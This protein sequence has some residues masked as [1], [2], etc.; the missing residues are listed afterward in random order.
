MSSQCKEWTSKI[1]DGWLSKTGSGL[2]FHGLTAHVIVL[3]NC[4]YCRNIGVN[5]TNT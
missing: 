5:D 1:S 3:Y 4:T 2:L